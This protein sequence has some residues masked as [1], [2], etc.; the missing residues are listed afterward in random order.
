MNSKLLG[1]FAGA[2]SLVATSAFALNCPTGGGGPPITL[3]TANYYASTSGHDDANSCSNSGNPCTP[4]GAIE[5]AVKQNFSSVAPVVN[6]AA[7]TYTTPIVVAGSPASGIAN[8]NPYYL[9]IAGAGSGTTSISVTTG[10]AALVASNGVNVTVSGLTFTSMFGSD[11]FPTKNAQVVIGEDVVIGSAGLGQ[12]HAEMGAQV[13][14]PCGFTVS[15][16]ATALFQTALG[17]QIGFDENANTVKF[18]GSPVYSTGFADIDQIGVLYVPSAW[19]NFTGAQTAQYI[20]NIAAGLLTVN[21]VNS[22]TLAVNNVVSTPGVSISSIPQGSTISSL[23]TGAGGTGTYHLSAGVGS[24]SGSFTGS[25]AVAAGVATLTAGAVTGTPLAVG[26]YINGAGLALDTYYIASGSG[27]TWVLNASP[28]T[29]GS[30]AMTVDY[31][32]YTY[33]PTTGVT[34]P[35]YNVTTNSIIETNTGTANY[36]PGSTAGQIASGGRYDPAPGPT[37]AETDGKLG[38]TGSIAL[39]SGPTDRVSSMV[40]SP[41]GAGIGTSGV[42]TLTWA[43]TFKGSKCSFTLAN[44]SGAWNGRATIILSG[45]SSTTKSITWDNNGVALTGGSTYFVNELCDVP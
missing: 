40:L 10:A 21:T 28:G 12:L 1:L 2:L 8:G 22:G 44:G 14:M 19:I 7:G 15:G 16:G 29:I 42:A 11:L 41:S 5:T 32:L 27:T 34:G 37:V 4:S 31:T 36:F 33:S 24:L 38:G 35:S 30:E 13:E 45:S 25:V 6:L 3:P 20:G 9:T 17:G 43:T 18:T 26:Q 39:G 23:G